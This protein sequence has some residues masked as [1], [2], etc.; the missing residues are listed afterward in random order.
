M[1]D[2]RDF[3]RG[4]G[5]HETI[6]VHGQR[7]AA[8]EGEIV[9]MRGEMN[10]RLTAQDVTLTTVTGTLGT[11]TATLGEVRE[12]IAMAKGGIAVLS[13]IGAFAVG[14]AT[15]I[16]VLPRVFHWLMDKP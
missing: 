12:M 9:E 2:E 3:D 11:L 14:I 13:K 4:T 7:L 10:R 5:T 1:A 15:L 16:Q 6:G 8:L